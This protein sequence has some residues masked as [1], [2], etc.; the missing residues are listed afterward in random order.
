MLIYSN[1]C[2]H[3]QGHGVSKSYDGIFAQT[4][5]GTE[6]FN[7]PKIE[8][9]STDYFSE[10]DKIINYLKGTNLENTLCRNALAGKGN[11]LIFMET[12]TFVTKCIEMNIK[13]DYI[14]LQLSGPNRKYKTEWD[15]SIRYMTPHEISCEN[16]L[17]FEPWGSLETLHWIYILQ[18]LFL[19]HN[20][21][22]VFVP[23]MEID[24]TAYN[25]SPYTKLINFN[26]FTE[27]VL[28]GHRNDFRK[29]GNFVV[30]EQGHPSQLGH[31]YLSKIC[32]SKLIPSLTLN[33]IEA[34]YTPH[35]IEN[36]IPYKDGK[37]IPLSEKLL[38]FIQ[39]NA[40][41]LGDGTLG[42]INILKNNKKD[43]L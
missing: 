15:G 42:E 43:L 21:S 41:K 22:Y 28:S 29:V 9:I 25:I 37:H 7:T 10:I 6:N 36:C 39:K 11:Y 3:T 12:Y 19:K 16:Q 38:N 27:N 23:Y 17:L 2:S 8:C 35:E 5:F 4:L 33:S 32:I 1:G 20:I 31:Y 18:E 30:D 40:Y 13:I 34:Y 14:I 26:K 24:E